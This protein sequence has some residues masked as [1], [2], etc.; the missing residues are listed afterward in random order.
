MRSLGALFAL[1]ALKASA[2]PVWLS[3]PEP[4]PCTFEAMASALKSRLNGATVSAGHAASGDVQIAL[5]HEGDGWTLSI[6]APG[7][8]EL[9]RPLG[10]PSDCVAFSEEAALIADRF[11]Q[12][13]QWTASAPVTPLPPPEPPLPWSAMLEVGGG[14][15]LGL[16]GVSGGGSIGLGARR[17]GWQVEIDAAF[18]GAGSVPISVITPTKA[19][20]NQYTGAAEVMLGRLIHFSIFRLRLELGGGA[21]LY[22][23][24]ASPASGTHPNPLPHAQLTL[25]PLAFGGAR[26]GFEV[27]LTSHLFAALGVRAR[28][29]FGQARFGVEGYPEHFVTHLVDGDAGLS[30]GYVFF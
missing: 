7:Q 28:V 24:G 15:T 27:A 19:S 6:V 22:F 14:P 2:G 21:E 12:S 4:A 9:R 5:E 1:L 11:L 13:I 26:V 16:T 3:L 23:V 18:L 29:H 20:L 25:T 17:S 30:V 8:P 10:E